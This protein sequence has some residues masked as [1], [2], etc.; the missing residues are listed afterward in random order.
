MS[1]IPVLPV[2][3]LV[4]KNGQMTSQW[5]IFFNQLLTELQN[6]ISNTGLVI[7]SQSATMVATLNTPPNQMANGTLIYDTTN[8]LAKVVINNVIKTIQ[9]V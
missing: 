4:D 7:P 8:N 1:A 3:A 9:T 5:N 2:C 6:N